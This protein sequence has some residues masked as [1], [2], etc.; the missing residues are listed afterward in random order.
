MKFWDSSALVP[1]F[2]QQPDSDRM[3]ALLQA[4][5]D[6]ILWWGSSVECA[7][8]FARLEREGHISFENMQKCLGQVN[9]LKSYW[10]EIQPSSRLKENCLRLLQ[11]HPLTAADSMQLAAALSA[12]EFRPFS[13]EFVCLDRKLSRAAQKEGFSSPF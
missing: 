6:V 13:L 4:D 8:A 3:I 12:S 10:T 2:A 7:S 1:L 11:V 5:P 9:Q